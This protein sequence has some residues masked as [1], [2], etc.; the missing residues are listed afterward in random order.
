MKITNR[1]LAR[2]ALFLTAGAF[3]LSAS[4]CQSGSSEKTA[5]SNIAGEKPAYLM[6]YFR[7]G[8]KQ[9]DMQRQLYYAFSRDGLHWYELNDNK[10]VWST[11][12]G[13]EIIR[14]PYLNKGPDGNYYL[15]HTMNSVSGSPNAR[16]EIG[17]AKSRD[18]ITFTDARPLNVMGN[19]SE[20]GNSWAPEWTWDEASRRYMVY[21]SSTLN[22]V[23]VNDNRIFKSYTTDWKTFT[24]AEP[25]FDPGHSII[26]ASITPYNG[27]YYMFFKDETARPMRNRMAVS[28]KLDSGYGSI[29]ELIT[30]NMTEAP[31]VL[32]VTGQQKWYL[33]YDYWADGKY[34]VME[35]TDMVHWSK[36]L[37]EDGF[38]F[39]YQRRHAAFFPI[40]EEELFKLINHFSLLAHYRRDDAG[41]KLLKDAGAKEEGPQTSFSLRSISLWMKADR[42]KGTQILY[43]EGSNDAGVAVRLEG[44]QLQAAAAD[45]GKSVTVSTPMKDTGTWH[46]VATVFS[47]GSLK[48]YVDGELKDAKTSSFIQTI[49][50][51]PEGGAFGKRSGKYAFGGTGEG[52]DFLGDLKE[53]AVYDIPLQE[54]DVTYLY[55]HPDT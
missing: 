51:Q 10:A 3:M 1:K 5:K 12:V 54:A 47:E 9:T 6:A 13:G 50:A 45:G 30:P 2:S 22:P 44:D 36:E 42:M 33:Y 40:S 43:D 28:D 53:A 32:Q 55:R 23:A 49:N 39:P 7:S 52:A 19:Y 21:W 38:R 17:F 24:P 25:V 15:V 46:H 16:K 41:G 48:L 31:E 18:L 29:S 4:A 26:D 27:K 14:D 37:P 34:G 8:P 20:V 35:S 11:P